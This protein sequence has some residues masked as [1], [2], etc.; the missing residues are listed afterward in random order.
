MKWFS[1]V[2]FLAFEV[3]DLLMWL[4]LLAGILWLGLRHLR[5]LFR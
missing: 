5:N 3:V 4:G 1:A 2:K